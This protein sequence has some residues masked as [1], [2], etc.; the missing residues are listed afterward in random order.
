MERGGA[1]QVDVVPSNET[2]GIKANEWNMVDATSN[3]QENSS[4]MVPSRQ[5]SMEHSPSSAVNLRE[6]WAR[7]T[8]KD[9]PSLN[10]PST[11]S[12]GGE[13]IFSN[14]DRSSTLA[15]NDGHDENLTSNS[16][17]EPIIHDSKVHRSSV[18]ENGDEN[19]R[20]HIGSPLLN[21]SSNVTGTGSAQLTEP[22]AS[23]PL[24]ADDVP[25]APPM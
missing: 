9:T 22:T 19:V 10:V 8:S 21:P 5:S 18:G 14:R 17:R 16:F 24:F 23:T 2:L 4:I 3:T 1:V 6:R 11:P 7:I 25:P 12:H 13:S 20:M 15:S